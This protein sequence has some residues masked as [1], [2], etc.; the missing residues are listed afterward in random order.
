[1]LRK[2]GAALVALFIFSS[3]GLCQNNRYDASINAFGL[4]TNTT[5]GNGVTQSATDG[6]G[7][8]AT[9]RF[10]FRPSHSLAVNFGRAKNSHVF[11]AGDSFH[12]LTNITEIT[13]SYM[14]TPFNGKHFE[15]FVQAGGGALIFTPRS[16]WVFF[17]PVNDV[18][19]N[20]QVEL[21]ATK[22][23]QLAFLYGLGV[24]CRVP[25]F[26]KLAIRLQYRGFVY[27][28][29]DFHVD[30]SAGSVTNF[31]T[32]GKG[33]MAEPSIGLVYRF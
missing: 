32:G 13:G 16:T 5:S 33:H 17:P 22:Q 8:F 2:A 19:N 29:P 15:P 9:M 3:L 18:P 10:R 31:F 11:Q 12:V 21:G 1:M 14:F 20:V 7:G 4:F 26:P 27:K 6:G 24:D 25:R 28:E 30:S 23:T